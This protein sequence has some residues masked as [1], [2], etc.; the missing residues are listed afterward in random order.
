M[1][2]NHEDTKSRSKYKFYPSYKDSETDFLGEIPREWIAIRVKHI[3]NLKGGAG[4]P[5]DEQGVSIEE[6]D[7]HKVNALGKAGLEGFL[8]KSE[9][10]IS[11][12][13]AKK[14]GAFVFPKKTIVFAKVGA[15]LLLARIRWLNSPSCVDNN[16]MGLVVHNTH[17]S[18][19]IKYAM[20]IIKFDYIVNP[21]A[22]PSLNEFQMGNLFLAAPAKSDQTKIANFLDHE[23]AKIDLLIEKQQQL[24]QLLKEK[25]QAVISHAVTKG[26][27]PNV[28]MKESGVEWLGEVPVDWSTTPLKLVVRTRKGVAFKSVDFCEVGIRVVKAS[29]IKKKTIRATDVFLPERFEYEYPKAL[30]NSSDIILSTVGSNPEVKNSAVGQI[31]MVPK[32]LTGSLLNQ[33]T[34]VFDPDETKLLR[35]YLFYILQMEGYRDHLDL[36]AH[37]T[38]NQSSLSIS[39]MLNFSICFPPIEEQTEVCTYLRKQEQKLSDL[40]LRS[41]D[42]ET[43]LRERRTALIS[44]AVTGKIDVR[45]WQA[46]KV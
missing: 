46:P 39:D 38:A 30:L 19:F 35:E 18:N 43:L 20:N 42:S 37:G 41:R 17:D 36:H 6:L 45:D 7:F 1:I 24:I 26:L 27:N 10:T 33:N 15:A 21:G 32:E 14:L 4:F 23:T 25:R 40:E 31:G 9:N 29:D 5:H 13:T 22:V 34:V 12:E 44:A 16:M 3:G 28:P 11:R 8:G 2:L